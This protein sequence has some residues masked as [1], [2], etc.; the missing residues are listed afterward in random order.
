MKIFGTG[1]CLLMLVLRRQLS[2]LLFRQKGRLFLRQT[3]QRTGRATESVD[4]T[5][6]SQPGWFEQS[7]YCKD[8]GNHNDG[9]EVPR[10]AFIVVLGGG[11]SD[12][13]ARQERYDVELPP[14]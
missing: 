9:S 5:A 10:Y 3:L 6:L 11:Q 8:S 4:R 13:G 14:L 12:H 1:V 2:L 7:P